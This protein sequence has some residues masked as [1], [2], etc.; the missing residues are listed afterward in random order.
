MKWFLLFLPLSCAAAEF[1][2][3]ELHQLYVVTI[4]RAGIGVPEKAP[5]VYAVSKDTMT[6]IACHREC[7]AKGFQAGDSIFYRDDLNPLDPQDMGVL[8]HEFTHYL[9][10]KRYG[11]PKDCVDKANRER[12]AYQ[13]Q[14]EFLAKAGLMMARPQIVGCM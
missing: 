12:E 4:G 14:A 11:N 6:E 2:A 1:N 7:E 5:R 8:V 9:Q 10:W 3:E 13:V